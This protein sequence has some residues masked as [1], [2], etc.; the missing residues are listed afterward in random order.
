MKWLGIRNRL[1]FVWWG[2]AAWDLDV[3][4]YDADLETL[5]HKWWRLGPIELV[6]WMVGEP[7]CQQDA[8]RKS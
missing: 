1:Q 4:V 2:W 8:K 3:G 6:V 7:T 5:M